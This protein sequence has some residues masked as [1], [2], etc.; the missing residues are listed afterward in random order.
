MQQNLRDFHQME[1]GTNCPHCGNKVKKLDHYCYYRW[2]GGEWSDLRHEAPQVMVPSLVQLCPHCGKHFAMT[3][4]FIVIND[5]SKVNFVDPV[6]FPALLHGAFNYCMPMSE[7]EWSSPEIEFN[8]RIRFLWAYNDYFYRND[9][10]HPEPDEMAKLMHHHNIMELLKFI[11]NPLM[12]CDLIRQAGDF[13]ECISQIDTLMAQAPEGAV[14]MHKLLKQKVLMNDSAPFVMNEQYKEQMFVKITETQ[15]FGGVL[16]PTCF[17]EGSPQFQLWYDIY[18]EG[19]QKPF[20]SNCVEV[21][22]YRG[23]EL[24]GSVR[25]HLTQHQLQRLC[26]LQRETDDCCGYHTM[27]RT[28][29]E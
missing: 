26:D 13:D 4:E 1:N 5:T 7:F 9:S 10:E 15:C 17:L 24:M 19:V 23:I 20:D 16:N 12:Q 28:Q 14:L 29:D 25:G 27:L 18:K 6:D 21:E 22:L 2:D 11:D 8:Q 3:K